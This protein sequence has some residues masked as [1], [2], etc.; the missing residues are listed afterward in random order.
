MKHFRMYRL[1][2]SVKIQSRKQYVWS[3]DTPRSD[4]KPC[5][6]CSLSTTPSDTGVTVPSSEDAPQVSET[7]LKVS[8]GRAR[9]AV[10]S[11][12]FT[13]GPS[14]RLSVGTGSKNQP[15][16]LA[17]GLQLRMQMNKNESEEIKGSW[18]CE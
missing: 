16:L 13:P 12:L 18:L 2:Q 15:R 17:S 11:H 5:T 6:G 14:S 4:G 8:A 9:R 1:G 10:Y 7:C 3:N